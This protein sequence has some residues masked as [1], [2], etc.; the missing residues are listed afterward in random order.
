MQLL[1]VS[2]KAD[3]GDSYLSLRNK[4]DIGTPMTVEAF[5][6]PRFTNCE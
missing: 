3:H 5:L 2:K 4:L 6:F 1:I